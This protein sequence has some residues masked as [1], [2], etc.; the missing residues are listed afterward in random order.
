MRLILSGHIRKVP[1]LPLQDERIVVVAE[2]WR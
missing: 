2:A 1:A